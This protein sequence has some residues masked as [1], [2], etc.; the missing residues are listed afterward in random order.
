MNSPLEKREIRLRGLDR[1]YTA[2]IQPS[3]RWWIGWVDEVG[4]VNSQ[5]ET[6]DELIANL[7]SAL[8]EAL[9]MR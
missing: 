6:R 1:V 5:A 9:E 2:T 7:G 8:D 3:G 4:G